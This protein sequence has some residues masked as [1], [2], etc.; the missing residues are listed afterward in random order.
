MSHLEGLPWGSS[1]FFKSHSAGKNWLARGEIPSLHKCTNTF[2]LKSL[3]IFFKT[4]TFEMCPLWEALLTIVD[5]TLRSGGRGDCYCYGLN[6]I[7]QKDM[8]KSKPSELVNETL[9][10]N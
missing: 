2:F 7:P 1:V 8:L 4:K 6:Y 10:A 3:K 5:E 9:F